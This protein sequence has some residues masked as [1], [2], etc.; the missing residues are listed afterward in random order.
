MSIDIQLSRPVTAHGEEIASL[1]LR[2][3]TPEDVMAVGMPSLLIPSADGESIGIEIR[4]KLI[5]QYIVRLAGV[6]LSTVKALSLADFTACQGVIMSFFG[7][8]A[9]EAPTN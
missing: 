5:G 3:P 1:T 7:S 8:G 4:A 2:E 9:G 6:P